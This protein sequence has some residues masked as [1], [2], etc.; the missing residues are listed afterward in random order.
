M[1]ACVE[2]VD[3]EGVVRISGADDVIS[4]MQR[5]IVPDF[6]QQS[7]VKIQ[8]DF[9]AS[10]IQQVRN[11]KSDIALFGTTPSPSELTGLVDHVI[12]YDAV[13]I[14]IDN[15]S[16]QGGIFSQGGTPLRKSDGFQNLS[17]SDLKSIFSYYITP[18]GFRWTWQ[19]YSWGVPIDLNTG[20]ASGS[21]TWL[22]QPKFI[23]PSMFFQP[24][25]YDTE[26]DLFQTLGINEQQVSKALKNQF[27][28]TNLNAEEE[29]LASEYPSGYP[30]NKGSADFPYKLSFASRRVIPLAMQNVPI[31]VVSINGINPLT[32]TQAVYNG[33]YPLSREI[34]VVT[35]SDCSLST[36][37]FV[38]YLLSNQ[39]QQA[40]ANAGYLPVQ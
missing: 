29:Y 19:Y 17:L 32:D 20:S 15:N 11:G 36:S 1:P 38:N 25:K 21:A 24:G 31:S 33:T 2:K 6:N 28:D 26:T 8:T 9:S 18:F 7:S 14:I 34:H 12:A 4:P 10:A 3:A 39:G 35:R 27:S 16:Y 5:L 37:Q 23:S 40:L 30:Y 22:Q 13:C